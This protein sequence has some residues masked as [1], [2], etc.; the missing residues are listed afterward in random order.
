MH[1]PEGIQGSGSPKGNQPSEWDL[2][3]ASEGITITEVAAMAD[4]LSRLIAIVAFVMSAFTF[5][6]LF[7]THE[8]FSFV[9]S[10]SGVWS[11]PDNGYFSALVVMYNEGNRSAALTSATAVFLDTDAEMT[12]QTLEK[13]GCDMVNKKVEYLFGVSDSKS[14]PVVAA[15]LQPGAIIGP[16]KVVTQNL[17]FTL[18]PENRPPAPLR[19][20]HMNGVVCINLA[21]S[22]DKGQVHSFGAPI[23]GIDYYFKEK[24]CQSI[25]PVLGEDLKP[26]KVIERRRIEFPF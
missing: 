13:V 26:V 17:M 12:R 19:P 8:S 15:L 2:P 23:A 3:S 24:N 7:L 16:G 1:P 22:D 25:T 21:F 5:C 6:L 11:S 9:V 4:W 18:L 14:S 10:S 20:N